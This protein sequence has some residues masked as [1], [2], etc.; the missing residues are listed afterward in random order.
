MRKRRFTEEQI[1]G[2]LKVSGAAMTGVGL[3]RRVAMIKPPGWRRSAR[4]KPR[5]AVRRASAQASH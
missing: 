1:I 4:A 2:V 5:A 3:M